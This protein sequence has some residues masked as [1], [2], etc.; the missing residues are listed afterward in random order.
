MALLQNLYGN[1]IVHSMGWTLLHACWQIILVVLLL[2]LVLPRIEKRS[3]NLAYWI[4]IGGLL[5]IALWSGYTFFE[6][7]NYF[8][9]AIKIARLEPL[10]N[11][12][13]PAI[14]TDNLDHA[15]AVNTEKVAQVEQ[16]DKW[17]DQVLF[18]LPPAV[19]L[20]GIGVFLLLFRLI[21]G[22]L[23]IYHLR[24]KNLRVINEKWVD[25][26]AELKNKLGIR[27]EVKFY[28][29]ERVQSPLTLGFFK[30]MVLVPIGLFTNLSPEMVETVLLHELAHIKRADYLVNILQSIVEMAFFFHPGIWWISKTIRQTREHA[31][32]DIAVRACQD[33]M[34]YAR[35]LTEL[36]STY[37]ST[38]NNL[39]MS[40]T[41]TTGSFTTRIKR[42]FGYAEPQRSKQKTV[43]FASVLFAC[44]LCFAFT[45]PINSNSITEDLVK[46]AQDAEAVMYLITPTTTEKQ[47][48]QIQKSLAEKEVA[49]QWSKLEF[50]VFGLLDNI[51]L[52]FEMSDAS[53]FEIEVGKLKYISIALDMSKDHPLD[54]RFQGQRLTLD[55]KAGEEDEGL[56]RMAKPFTNTYAIPSMVGDLGFA[57]V[58][59]NKDKL[60]INADGDSQPVIV[61]NGAEVSQEELDAKKL[62]PNDIFYI[63]KLKPGRAQLILKRAVGEEEEVYEVHSKVNLTGKKKFGFLSGEK[64]P[65]TQ[66][67]FKVLHKAEL[68]GINTSSSMGAK[69]Y[70]DFSISADNCNDNKKALHVLNDQILETPEGACY[71][72]ALKALSEVDSF[73]IYN[74]DLATK[75]FGA[76]GASGAYV[77]Y[78]KH[79]PQKE[80]TVFSFKPKAKLDFDRVVMNKPKWENITRTKEAPTAFLNGQLLKKNEDGSWPEELAQVSVFDSLV[81]LTSPG[82]KQAYGFTSEEDVWLFYKAPQVN[83]Y[84]S[85]SNKLTTTTAQ[86]NLLYVLND[87]IL[88][89]EPGRKTPSILETIP[90]D[91]YEKAFYLSGTN[92][93]DKYGEAGNNGVMELYT[94]A[95]NTPSDLRA[96]IQVSPNPFTE[97]LAIDLTLFDKGLV[98]IIVY[99]QFGRL[100][101]DL[102]E[103]T[104]EKGIH[105]F[106]W[107]P[108]AE[109]TSGMYYVTVQKDE[110]FKSYPVVYQGK[111]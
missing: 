31:C 3:A 12:D 75:L 50:S 18:Y 96:R 104:L 8:D 47:L 76:A 44:F 59:D 24:T 103:E 53:T 99:D 82:S 25:R 68:R 10:Y 57:E 54:V 6:Q 34:L 92:A 55:P 16:A 88:F 21:M 100:I 38:T 93:T 62:T 61:L 51:H 73:F 98:K 97:R 4:S 1:P 45:K 105:S 89:T 46:G 40:L 5:V 39:A 109:V 19:V 67:A 33:P 49:M 32:D 17:M 43:L 56:A 35:T 15:I 52:D 27:K 41:G 78:Y 107:Y 37:L 26:F 60:V 111:L 2:R 87:E 14:I 81:I 106:Y 13:N 72:V 29:S 30:P 101:D 84:S 95:E 9:E 58:S 11:N 28:F 80:E 66:F 22:W 83:G 110:E 79:K 108:R 102:T 7:Y 86:P 90:T 64:N 23:R 91:G 74:E 85:E 70:G 20:W 42:L 71:P 69:G 77:F 94:K 36:Q 63:R 48:V 65:E